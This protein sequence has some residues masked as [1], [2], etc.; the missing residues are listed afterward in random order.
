V[1][2]PM[3]I[4]EEFSKESESI[5]LILVVVDMILDRASIESDGKCFDSYSYE[6]GSQNFGK[7]SMKVSQAIV[8]KI[9]CD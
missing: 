2:L 4:S 1:Q 5:L 3:N 9:G 6:T 7:Q 8:M